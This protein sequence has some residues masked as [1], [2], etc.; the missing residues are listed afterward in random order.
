MMRVVTVLNPGHPQTSPP[1]PR[2]TQRKLANDV[3]ITHTQNSDLQSS[4]TCFHCGVDVTPAKVHGDGPG[5]H[6]VALLCGDTQQSGELSLEGQRGSL[7]TTRGHV[8][9]PPPKTHTVMFDTGMLV[10]DGVVDVVVL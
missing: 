10:H 4:Q 8:L 7:G 2:L 6:L 5:L 9:P 3:I 1:T